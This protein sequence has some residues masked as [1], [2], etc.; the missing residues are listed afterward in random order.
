MRRAA[1]LA[2]LFAVAAAAAFLLWPDPEMPP[3][4]V[5]ADTACTTCDARQ[6]AKQRLRDHLR[7]AQ[8]APD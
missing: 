8:T 5:A 7:Q 3:D 6:K 2:V 1:P 4:A